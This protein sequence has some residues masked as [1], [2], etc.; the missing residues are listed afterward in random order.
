MFCAYCF[1]NTGELSKSLQ[2]DYACAESVKIESAQ[3]DNKEKTGFLT[4]EV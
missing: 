3:K 2:A 4:M 1:Q